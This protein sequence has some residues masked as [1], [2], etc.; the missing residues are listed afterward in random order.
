MTFIAHSFKVILRFKKV[1]E[2]ELPFQILLSL[3]LLSHWFWFSDS[4]HLCL[5]HSRPYKK[6]ISITTDYFILQRQHCTHI[7]YFHRKADASK[8]ELKLHKL[9][10]SRNLFYFVFHLVRVHEQF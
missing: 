2:E 6:L 7:L 8:K 1:L 9:D 10:L 3:L 5:P 4:G